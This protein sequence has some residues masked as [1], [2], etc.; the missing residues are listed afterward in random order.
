[1]SSTQQKDVAITTQVHPGQLL[2]EAREK[3]KLTVS[4]IASNLHLEKRIIEALEA[5]DYNNLPAA[6]YVRGYLRAYARTVNLN[7]DNI[8]SLYNPDAPEPPEILPEVKHR[9]QISSSDK[10]VK[11]VTY[12]ITLGLVLLLLIWWQS[13]YVIDR[14]LIAEGVSPTTTTT[15]QTVSYP[16]GFDYE[17]KIVI[18][19]DN[20]QT[21]Y[22]NEDLDAISPAGTE[23]SAG[24]DIESQPEGMA[25]IGLLETQPLPGQE[26]Q[27]DVHEN[28]SATA[29]SGPDN[30][31]M[32]LSADCWI[33]VSD[34]SDKII[35][36][37]LARTGQDLLINGTA[38]FTVVLGY[39]PGVKVT[40]NGESFDTEPLSIGGVARFTLG[41]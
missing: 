6:T 35:Y 30:I 33:E 3:L 4:D 31:M 7:G 12:L 39:A 23:A 11:A 13:H 14:S 29:S 40:F 27:F 24:M 25:T 10:P 21:G 41:E 38:P 8:I 2:C 1:M 19:P 32:Q 20:W 28:E 36:M 15:D 9:T 18:H 22:G 17:Y 34:T 37:D 16:Q 5:D 26:Q